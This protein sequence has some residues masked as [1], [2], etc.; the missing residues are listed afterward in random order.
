MK[1]RYLPVLFLLSSSICI[2]AQTKYTQTNI[3][4]PPGAISLQAMA[5][6]DLGE[7]IGIYYVSQDGTVP[8]IPFLY[9]NGVTTPLSISLGA[10]QASNY[11]SLRALNNSAEIAG[12]APVSNGQYHAF[13]VRHGRLR[14]LGTLVQ[15]AAAASFA[16]AINNRGDIVGSSTDL[17]GNEVPVAWRRGA[18]LDLRLMLAVPPVGYPL[19]INEREQILFV[20]YASPVSYIWQKKNATLVGSVAAS[21]MNNQGQVIGT[22]VSNHAF[23]WSNGTLLDLH[24]ANYAYSYGQAINNR[25]QVAG[26]LVTFFGP[27]EPRVHAGLWQKGKWTDFGGYLACAKAVNNRGQILV[28]DGE[29]EFPRGGFSYIL[30]PKP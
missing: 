12:S 13:V 25:G 8:G 18:L 16:T 20:D 6:N 4:M 11:V 28:V 1:L 23:L 17:N 3:P 2:S 29:G 14:D 30:T 9:R 10:N 27:E 5:M 7:V 19:A 15:T 22:T 21:G 24:P 26:C